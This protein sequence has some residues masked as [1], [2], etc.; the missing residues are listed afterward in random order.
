MTG[1]LERTTLNKKSYDSIPSPNFPK[2]VAM[3][4][5]PPKRKS[6]KYIK[7]NI[8]SLPISSEILKY[9][10]SVINKKDF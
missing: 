9:I 5:N 7:V 4:G 6:P 1:W 3:T 10:F 8:F 2:L